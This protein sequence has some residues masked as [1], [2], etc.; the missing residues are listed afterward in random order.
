M[1]D[2]RSMVRL[3]GEKFCSDKRNRCDLSIAFDA[4]ASSI[5]SSDLR[6]MALHVSSGIASAS[7]GTRMNALRSLHASPLSCESGAFVAGLT[8]DMSREMH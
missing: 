8:T 1:R 6:S 3:R 5:V 2:V 4:V 7:A